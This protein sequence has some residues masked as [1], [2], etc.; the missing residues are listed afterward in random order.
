MLY[1]IHQLARL[2][3]VTTRTLRHYDEIGL[4]SPLGR[5]EGNVRLYGRDELETLQAVLFYRRF[6]MPLKEIRQILRR[7]ESIRREDMKK[8][9]E[10]LQSERERLDRLIDTIAR[11]IEEKDDMKDDELFQGLK[12]KLVED[13]E[14]HYGREVRAK[15]GDV[16][17]D[18]ANQTMMNLSKDDMKTQTE[19]AE[20]ILSELST[21]TGKTDPASTQGNRLADM[22]RRWLLHFWPSVTKEAHLGLARMYV[23]DE[24]F[25]AY[26][27]LATPGATKHL[28]SCIEAYYSK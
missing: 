3:G 8:H 7:D 18:A 26:Y 15:Y 5:S 10:R 17:V 27:D 25:T 12:Q 20:A 22:H 16:E 4:V 9:L 24:R 14:T 21:Q 2:S 28:L 13:N 23:E 19:L 1:T 11:T 6:G